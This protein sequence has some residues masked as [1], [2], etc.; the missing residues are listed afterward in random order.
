M[1]KRV[2]NILR[3]LP[4]IIAL[5]VGS[6]ASVQAA[7]KSA[8][9]TDITGNVIYSKNITVGA[10]ETLYIRNGGALYITEGTVLTV[11][12]NVKCAQGGAIYSRGK[13]VVND[14]GLVSVT[15]KL[16]LMSMGSIELGGKLMVNEKGTLKG[17]GRVIMNCDFK[18]IYCTGRISAKL[19]P[20]APVTK[21]GV[22]T[23]G[24]VLVVNREYGLP[25]DYG[26]GLVRSAYSAYLKMKS[27]SGYDMELISGFRS[28]EKQQQVYKYW[29]SIDGE[30]TASRYSAKPG[31]SEHQSGLAMDITSCHTSYGDTPEGKWLAENCWRYG[32]IIRYPE[33]GEPITGYIYE[34]WHVRYLGTSLAKMVYDSGLTLE[35]F[36]C[37]A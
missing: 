28:Y 2:L 11:N 26:D 4:L 29:C 3:I 19:V 20:P 16:K 15:G 14:G 33:G 7:A 8:K 36:F 32:F 23:V 34:P 6:T 22:T 10:G 9:L 25:E 17:L 31:H 21:D 1:K 35:E 13:I 37:I 18:N 12:G 24:G 30:E 27:D 5:V